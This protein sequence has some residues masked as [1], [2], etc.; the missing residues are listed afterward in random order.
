M[1][2]PTDE[3]R[4]RKYKG[5][6]ATDLGSSSV[7]LIEL[8]QFKDQMT[9]TKKQQDALSKA[10]PQQRESMKKLFAS[11][12]RP[13]ENSVPMPKF[14]PQTQAK[15]QPKSKPAPKRK[16]RRPQNNRGPKRGTIQRFPKFMPLPE[17][18]S[19]FLV[20]DLPNVMNFST[21]TFGSF[22]VFSSLRSYGESNPFADSC[23]TDYIAV[24]RHDSA[25]LLSPCDLYVRCAI[26]NTPTLIGSKQN[27]DRR[28]RLHSLSTVIRC[29]GVNGGLYPVGEVWIGKTYLADY[30]DREDQGGTIHDTI[31]GPLVQ[32]GRMHAFSAVDLLKPV[33]VDASIGDQVSYKQWCD[34]QVESDQYDPGLLEPHQG[35]ESIVM[36]IPPAFPKVHYRISI[37]TTWCVRNLGD[38][39]INSSMRSYPPTKIDTWNKYCE[40]LRDTKPHHVTSN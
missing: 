15:P 28:V 24:S 33:R 17:A 32:S 20:L 5:R 23:V 36:W 31:I 26:A 27:N 16:P 34:L 1:L 30:Y 22:I 14:M 21:D 25:Q 37:N 35:M 2:E 3:P 29:I 10:T 19:P 7:V 13:A 9:Y 12:Q 6:N 11:Q 39:L 38:V 18:E 4:Q 8:R 40:K